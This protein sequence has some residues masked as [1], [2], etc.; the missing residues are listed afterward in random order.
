VNEPSTLTYSHLPSYD[1]RLIEVPTVLAHFG[2]KTAH[3]FQLGF[4]G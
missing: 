4:V 2:A 3:G 1:P